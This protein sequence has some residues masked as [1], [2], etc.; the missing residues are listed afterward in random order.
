[1]KLIEQKDSVQRSLTQID[2]S[3]NK[4]KT[5]KNDLEIKNAIEKLKVLKSLNK[6]IIEQQE[7]QKQE[8]LLSEKTERIFIPGEPLHANLLC[9]RQITP[10]AVK[11][12][13]I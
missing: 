8:I 9:R 10:N 2:A 5:K 12:L 1:M 6:K 13:K 3:I 4:I 7:P 11:Q